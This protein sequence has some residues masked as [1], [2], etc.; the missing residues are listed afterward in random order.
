M[1]STLKQIDTRRNRSRPDVWI[2]RK[3]RMKRCSLSCAICGEQARTFAAFY[4]HVRLEHQMSVRQYYESHDDNP[5]AECGGRI[6]W[7]KSRPTTHGRKFCSNRC[8]GRRNRGGNH[9]SW[10]GGAIV[11]G[12]RKVTIYAFPEQY[13]EILAPMIQG[14]AAHNYVLEHRAIMAIQLGRT[15]KPYETVH[16]RNGSK[17]DNRP[18]NLE[19]WLGAH[20]ASVRATEVLCP[21]CGKHYG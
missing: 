15:L 5:C 16:H 7:Y 3:R 19:L 11:G 8:S 9:K 14:K 17:L 12:Y 6:P 1:I 20:G 21:H 13:H 10:K 2:G 18:E 4:W